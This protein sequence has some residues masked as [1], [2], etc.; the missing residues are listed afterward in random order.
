MSPSKI[1]LALAS[2]LAD[3]HLLDHPFYRRWEAGAVSIHELRAYAAQYRYF[4]RYLPGFLS[5]L[6][7]G[8]EHG[9]AR[10]LVVANLADEEGDPVPHVKL[11][12]RFATA[13]GAVDDVASPAT[14][15]LLATYTDLLRRGPVSALAGFLAYECQAAEIAE[16]KASG[17][18]RHYGLD[19]AGVSFWDHHASVDVTHRAWASQALDLCP[20]GRDGF[21]SDIRLA[22]DA[23]WDFLD[24]REACGKSLVG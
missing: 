22:A 18:R 14:S 7:E 12:E 21:D 23:W 9:P 3:R 1:D 20:E 24:E 17:L 8:L 6:A 2:A 10:D 5:E 4:E 11:F 13:V 16:S 19:D 15:T